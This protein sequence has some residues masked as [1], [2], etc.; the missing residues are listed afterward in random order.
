M[1]WCSTKID[2]PPP[3][4]KNGEFGKNEKEKFGLQ[5]TYYNKSLETPE[6]NKKSSGPLKP[7]RGPYKDNAHLTAQDARLAKIRCEGEYV[8][9][10]VGSN[11]DECI[12]LISAVN[13]LIGEENF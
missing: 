4:Y 9:R 1:S 13:D 3:E 6:D 2:Y 12:N 7:V 11:A 5:I 10:D 8:F